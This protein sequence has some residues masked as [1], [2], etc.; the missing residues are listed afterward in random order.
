MRREMRAQQR[1]ALLV[2]QCHDVGK[3]LRHRFVATAAG[4]AGEVISLG[5]ADS[6]GSARAG[7]APPALGRAAAGVDAAARAGETSGAVGAGSAVLQRRT[8][9]AGA[10]RSAT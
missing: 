6:R 8:S 10:G 9:S 4:G 2:E 5:A 3:A 7:I 1:L